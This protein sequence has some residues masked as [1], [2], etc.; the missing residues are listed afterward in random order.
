MG[1]KILAVP[2]SPASGTHGLDLSSVPVYDVYLV[3]RSDVWRVLGRP[4]GDPSRS[5]RVRIVHVGTQIT[6]SHVA[7]GRIRIVEVKPRCDAGQVRQLD[8]RNH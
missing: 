7:N 8:V 1:S 4:Q 5:V 3:C 6:H 2:D